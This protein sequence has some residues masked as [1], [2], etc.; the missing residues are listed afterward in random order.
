[1]SLKLLRMG[2]DY[3]VCLDRTRKKK[4]SALNWIVGWTYNQ[5]E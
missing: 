1:M 5:S 4:I 2:F 3:E